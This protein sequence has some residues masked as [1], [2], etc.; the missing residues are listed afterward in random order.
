MQNCPRRCRRALVLTGGGCAHRV[1]TFV[2][3]F[4]KDVIQTRTSMVEVEREVEEERVRK[5][6]ES[7][8]EQRF[9]PAVHQTTIVVLA[10]VVLV[11]A[12]EEGTK[13][14][15]ERSGRVMDGYLYPFLGLKNYYAFIEKVFIRL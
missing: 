7:Q 5:E 4:D 2:C 15:R 8:K 10:V 12:V 13:Q 3:W 1:V 6:A 9:L 11:V 14:R